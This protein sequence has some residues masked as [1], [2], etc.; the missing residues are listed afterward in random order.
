MGRCGLYRIGTYDSIHG[1]VSQDS[2][3][4][5][6]SLRCLDYLETRKLIWNWRRAYY[7]QTTQTTL[8]VMEEVIIR[9]LWTEAHCL[10]DRQ[11]EVCQSKTF[12]DHVQ[13]QRSL[14][15]V[16][17]SKLSILYQWDRRTSSATDCRNSCSTSPGC[18]CPCCRVHSPRWPTWGRTTRECRA[19]V[20]G[21]GCV[22][23]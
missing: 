20:S 16:I 21:S 17:R 22:A 1:S 3:R 9:F 14:P 23:M 13:T 12:Q 19:L 11:E 7:V 4:T 18:R 6:N 8:G 2:G 15:Q 10:Q 5:C